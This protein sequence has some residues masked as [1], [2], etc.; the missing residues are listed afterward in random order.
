MIQYIYREEPGL[1]L[2]ML[3]LL[4]L[5]FNGEEAYR[6]HRDNL[7]FDPSAEKLY[8]EFQE[9]AADID[10]RLLAFFYYRL[11]TGVGTLLISYMRQFYREFMEEEH[12]VDAFLQ[13]LRDWT[14]LK[15]FA[16]REY[17]PDMSLPDLGE[18]DGDSV[19]TTVLASAYPEELK[20]Y[21]LSFLLSPASEAEF[22]IAE[23]QKA[24]AICREIRA[25]DRE[26]LT[27]FADNRED[28]IVEKA[29][30]SLDMKKENFHRICF[31]CCSVAR[32]TVSSLPYG[33]TYLLYVGLGA[34]EYLHS[35]QKQ[36]EID[37]IGLSQCLQDGQRLRILAMLQKK[38]MYCAEI[39]REL[40][41][42]NNSTL[43]HMNML[44]KQGLLQTRVEGHRTMYRLNAEYLRQ[45]SDFAGSMADREERR[46]KEE[47][48]YSN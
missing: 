34:R 25:G 2:D 18:P 27:R 15:R 9:R 11:E 47:R 41:L 13:S 1:L 45:L 30:L 21:L 23:L 19:R 3:F 22:L 4:K 37:W 35:W 28:E 6:E 10:P 38:E 40:G 46:R 48:K 36:T 5:R 44:Q 12:T 17:F 8:R 16:C 29:G 24:L 14:R 33:D 39:A 26:L 7:S 20:L 31:T 32:Q 42:K 43:Y